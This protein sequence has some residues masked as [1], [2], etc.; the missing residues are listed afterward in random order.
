M[1]KQEL[2]EA[3]DCLDDFENKKVSYVIE[4]L[5]FLAIPEDFDRKK[6]IIDKYN[7]YKDILFPKE[8]FK[9]FM[10]KVKKTKIEYTTIL[11]KTINV[12]N[13]NE[14]FNL[15]NLIC[16]S[17]IENHPKSDV[18]ERLFCLSLLSTGLVVDRMAQITS[19]F[20]EYRELLYP[21]I[22][23]IKLMEEI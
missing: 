23:Y 5:F 22:S 9:D 13:D 11:N 7:S 1:N 17:N 8:E 3:I 21:G 6:M 4:K 18:Y 12:D 20:I 19:K 16:C 2:L 15:L 14:R 10:E